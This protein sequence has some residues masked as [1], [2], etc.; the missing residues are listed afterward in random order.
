MKKTILTL[1]T[2]LCA[3]LLFISCQ[4]ETTSGNNEDTTA[5]KIETYKKALLGTSWVETSDTIE[6]F[7]GYETLAFKESSVVLGGTE[8][9]I[10]VTKDLYYYNEIPDAANTVMVENEFYI[11]VNNVYLGFECWIWENLD[12]LGLRLPNKRFN[13][14]KLVSSSGSSTSDG[15]TT[16]ASSVNGTYSYKASGTAQ[17]G[18]LTLKDGTWSYSGSKT[19]LSVKSGTYTVSGSKITVNW[20]TQGYDNTET[21]TISNSGSQSTWTSEEDQVSL[22]FTTIFTNSSTTLTF[23]KS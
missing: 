6:G 5:E 12:Y 14:Y 15:T 16:D 7:D 13:D 18:A 19:A 22:F 20:S 23:T 1:S 8:Y 17:S 21:F 4:N 2:V 11:L 9:P 3:G 10:D